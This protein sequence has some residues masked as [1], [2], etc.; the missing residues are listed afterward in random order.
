VYHVERNIV[1]Q[2]NKS[3]ILLE[4]NGEKS[5][6]KQETCTLNICYFILSNQVEKGKA[7]IDHCMNTAIRQNQ[8]SASE[9]GL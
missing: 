4:T 7:Q 2:D 5:L 8:S 9:F 1:Y 6:G 3:A